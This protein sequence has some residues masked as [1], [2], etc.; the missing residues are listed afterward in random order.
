MLGP[1]N[2]RGHPTVK[3]QDWGRGGEWPLGRGMCTPK[4]RQRGGGGSADGE[5]SV[6][7]STAAAADTWGLSTQQERRPQLP[8]CPPGLQTP[9][10]RT[11]PT[12]CRDRVL[13]PTEDTLFQHMRSL[14]THIPPSFLFSCQRAQNGNGSSCD[15]VPTAP[16]PHPIIKTILSALP[17]PTAVPGG[18]GM[19]GDGN[20]LR[21]VSE[22]GARCGGLR[23]AWAWGEGT[24]ADTHS[25]HPTFVGRCGA[26]G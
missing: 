15:A 1:A 26:S 11:A 6:L 13:C 4:L 22:A 7:D 16:L 24:Q 18:G 20:A 9:A 12:G 8:W 2:R 10:E 23:M 3:L 14:G 25:P 17:K 19:E 21:C 5:G